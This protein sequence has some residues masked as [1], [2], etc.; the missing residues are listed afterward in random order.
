MF[1][2]TCRILLQLDS[3]LLG[4]VWNLRFWLLSSTRVQ[5]DVGHPKSTIPCLELSRSRFPAT[6]II[7]YKSQRLSVLSYA[8]K[9][10]ILFFCLTIII[11]MITQCAINVYKHRSSVQI[12]PIG[13]FRYSVIRLTFDR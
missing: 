2:N 6:T 5:E 13:Y 1:S 12:N 7:R 9:Y 4:W 10:I 11:Y 8:L 3:F